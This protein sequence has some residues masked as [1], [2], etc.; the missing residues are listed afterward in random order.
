M[1]A[2]A[3]EIACCFR[4]G[5]HTAHIRIKITVATVAVDREGKALFRPLDPEDGGVGAGSNNRI[6]ANEMI[7][8]PINPFLRCDIR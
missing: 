5:Q 3:R 2:N 1:G 7:I 8:L 6:A 4:H